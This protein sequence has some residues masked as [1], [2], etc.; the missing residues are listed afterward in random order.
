MLG[1]P[2]DFTA[3]PVVAPP[4]P[5][6]ETVRVHAVRPERDELEICFPRVTGY[7]VEPPN[8]RLEADFNEDHVLVLTPELVGSTEVR[9]SGI[10]GEGV[11]LNVRH[12]ESTRTNRVLY[13]MTKHLI[14]TKWRDAGEA[15]KLHLFGQLKRIA[16]QWLETCLVCHGGTY[17]AQLLYL[18]LMDWACDRIMAAIVKAGA[19]DGL[20]KAVLNPYNPVGTTADVDFYTS[21]T[22][23]YRTDPRRSHVNWAVLDSSWE[24]EFCRVVEGHQ[25]VLA[26]VKN[27]NL[28]FTVPYRQGMENRTYV[29]DFIVAVDDGKGP[30]DP[31]NLVVEIKGY[32]GEDAKDKKKTMDSYWV[33]GVNNLGTFGRWAFAEFRDVLEMEGDFKKVIRNRFGHLVRVALG[34]PAAIAAEGIIRMGGTDPDAWV[35]PRKRPWEIWG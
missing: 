8:D 13:E 3:E 30:D 31:L 22:S 12:L 2:F 1:I 10:V 33:P 4:K 28:G 27:H 14:Y 11:D 20:V 5:P 25:Q 32:R 24:G 19:G 17:P 23:R 18:Q 16:R 34:D 15:P 7:R 9:N 21:K 6:R 29:P 35:P 26:Y